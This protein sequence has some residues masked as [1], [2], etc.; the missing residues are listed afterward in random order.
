MKD[1]TEQ[2]ANNLLIARGVLVPINFV[3]TMKMWSLRQ[4]F[5]LSGRLDI[6]VLLYSHTLSKILLPAY[7]LFSICLRT[8]QPKNS[9]FLITI[10]EV[11]AIFRFAKDFLTQYIMLLK[12]HGFPQNLVCDTVI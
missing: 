6:R 1:F 7:Y 10:L 11:S 5:S 9:R 4:H 8:S 3:N 2:P 12:L